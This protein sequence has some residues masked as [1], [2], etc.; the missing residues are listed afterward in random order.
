MTGALAN[1]QAVGL[2]I[3]P[4]EQLKGFPEGGPDALHLSRTVARNNRRPH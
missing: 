2:D 4:T 3:F 1:R